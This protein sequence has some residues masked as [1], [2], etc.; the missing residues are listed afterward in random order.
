MLLDLIYKDEITKHSNNHSESNINERIEKRVNDFLNDEEVSLIENR[1]ATVEYTLLNEFEHNQ[2]MFYD[3]DEEIHG[4]VSIDSAKLN[5]IFG[6]G[7]IDEC[8]AKMQKMKEDPL[9][10]AILNRIEELKEF[11]RYDLAVE[12]FNQVR[13]ARDLDFVGAVHDE[14]S[15]AERYFNLPQSTF[16][17]CSPKNSLLPIRDFYK[18]PDAVRHRLNEVPC[19]NVYLQ[20]NFGETWRLHLQLQGF[21]VFNPNMTFDN[22]RSQ[23]WKRKFDIQHQQEQK[24]ELNTLLHNFRRRREFF[25]ERELAIENF[26]NQ[27]S[28]PEKINE[29]IAS[30]FNREFFRN[31]DLISKRSETMAK[32]LKK[33]SFTRLRQKIID[34]RLI[35]SEN[36]KLSIW[37]IRP[38]ASIDEKVNENLGKRSGHETF[39][40]NEITS[41]FKVNPSY[42]LPKGAAERYLE[43]SLDPRELFDIVKVEGAD[44]T[45]TRHINKELRRVATPQEQENANIMTQEYLREGLWGKPKLEHDEFVRDILKQIRLSIG[46]ISEKSKARIIGDLNHIFF[47]RINAQNGTFKFG[48]ENDRFERADLPDLTQNKKRIRFE[49]RVEAKKATTLE[50]ILGPLT[51][52]TDIDFSKRGSIGESNSNLKDIKGVET[53]LREQIKLDASL[54]SNLGFLFSDDH[55]DFIQDLVNRLREELITIAQKKIGELWISNDKMKTILPKLRGVNDVDSESKFMGEIDSYLDN[56]LRF[57]YFNFLSAHVFFR[58]SFMQLKRLESIFITLRRLTENAFTTDDLRSE[59][60]KIFAVELDSPEKLTTFV[61][62]LDMVSSTLSTTI[63][64]Y[65]SN[66]HFSEDLLFL[67]GDE[68]L[69]MFIDGKSNMRNKPGHYTEFYKD[70]VE[71]DKR[72]EVNN[73]IPELRHEQ[74]RIEALK[75]ALDNKTTENSSPEALER[76][77]RDVKGIIGSLEKNRWLRSTWLGSLVKLEGYYKAIVEGDDTG[78][79]QLTPKIFNDAYA[80]LVGLQQSGEEWLSAVLEDYVEN[81]FTIRKDAE[82]VLSQVELS[83]Y[84]AY[85]GKYL[86]P[87]NLKLIVTFHVTSRL[88]TSWKI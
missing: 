2:Q 50:E 15:T 74:A 41:N 78:A 48:F 80:E 83:A 61:R 57:E 76:F 59:M 14:Y 27:D 55:P 60:S 79:V 29:V 12:L 75:L 8:I 81:L 10:S 30:S 84:D 53:L 63:N 40:F 11:E 37:N 23:I 34:L 68:A 49:N 51:D 1:M 25:G 52:L 85:F 19:T 9:V 42:K 4:P 16:E 73:S 20:K 33:R 82:K 67:K 65:E 18:M 43:G 3:G 6:R 56:N 69:R 62:F 26:F 28:T 86:T 77:K 66:L 36:E 47:G 71:Q 7:S 31:V 39:Y 45:Y 13:R 22:I 32:V 5:Y 87:Q 17:P 64:D 70:F 54:S 44:S 38:I 88:W 46:S 72:Q 35:T 24:D 58:F 21:D